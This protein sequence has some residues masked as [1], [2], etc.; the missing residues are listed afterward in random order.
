MDYAQAR[1]AKLKK[2]NLAGSASHTARTR[3]TPNADSTK[4]NI[5]FIGSADP[6][7]KLEDLVIAKIEQHKQKRKIRTDGVYCVELLLTASPS[8]FRP[9]DPTKGY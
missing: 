7:E 4:Q 9:D 6:N 3:P 1:L 8:Y 2:A 5:R